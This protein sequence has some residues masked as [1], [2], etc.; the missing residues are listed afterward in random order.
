MSHDLRLERTFD[1][2]PEVVFDAF[3]DPHAQKELYADAPDWVVEAD[4]DL[5]VGG[6]WTITFGPPGG[7]PAREINVFQVVDRPWRL[8][9]TSTMTMP[10][11]ATIDTDMEVTFRQEHGQTRMTIVQRGFPTAELRDEFANGWPSI[12]DGLARVVAATAGG[13]QA[14]PGRDPAVR[15]LGALVGRWRSEGH[16]VG[17]PHVPVT[18]TDIYEWLPGGFFLVHHVDVLVG[19]Q[20]VQAI[21]LIGERDPATDAFLARAYDNE[22][23]VTTMRATVDD[24]GVWTFTGGADVAAAAQPSSAEASGAVR[25]TLTVSGDRSSMTARWERSDDGATWQ[26]WMDMAFTRM[27]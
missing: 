8:V 15:R 20:K 1:A 9:Y 3:T 21:E 27:R 11:G 26:P 7:A 10:D 16:V 12:L 24:A 19:E 25:S 4:C 13:A 23:S 2:A 18:G 17:E 6:R 22:G 5:R 14:G